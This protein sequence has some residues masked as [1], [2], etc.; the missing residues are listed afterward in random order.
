M[1]RNIYLVGIMGAGKSFLGKKLAEKFGCHFVDLDEWIQEKQGKTVAEIFATQG[2][3]QFRKMEQEALEYDLPIDNLVLATGGGTPCFF[4]NMQY[5]LRHG[6]VIWLNPPLDKV[7]A[8]IWKMKQKRP[9]IAHAENEEK[10]VEILRNLLQQREKF[11]NQAHIIYTQDHV[12]E[13]PL[14]QSIRESPN[15]V[16]NDNRLS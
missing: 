2:E 16:D 11:Y 4:N 9:L 1:M 8:R 5:M 12:D 15:F 3:E 6:I 14:V 10:V 7:A 13:G